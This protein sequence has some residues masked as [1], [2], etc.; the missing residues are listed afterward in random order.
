MFGAWINGMGS[1]H[2]LKAWVEGMGWGYGSGP[3][4]EGMGLRYGLK[5]WVK[6]MG[7][8][9]GFGPWSRLGWKRDISLKNRSSSVYHLDRLPQGLCELCFKKRNISFYGKEGV[10]YTPKNIDHT[11]V[12][13]TSAGLATTRSTRWMCNVSP[14]R[15]LCQGWGFCRIIILGVSKIITRVSLGV[16]SAGIQARTKPFL[17]CSRLKAGVL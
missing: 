11:V 5:A 3:W 9:Y 8:R 10:L 14:G 12:I 4:D 13:S 15:S 1:I 2:G 7:Q 17:D 16:F 6:V